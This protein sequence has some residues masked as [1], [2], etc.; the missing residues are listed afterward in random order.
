MFQYNNLKCGDCNRAFCIAIDTDEVKGDTPICP[1]CNS[2]SVNSAA[3]AGSSTQETAQPGGA[4]PL[5][6]L[7]LL[8]AV[9]NLKNSRS[10]PR[11][12]ERCGLRSMWFS[13]EELRTLAQ[14]KSDREVSTVSRELIEWAELE[15][16]QLLFLK[17]ILCKSYAD[18][19]KELGVGA[20]RV[21]LK[22]N[23][24]CDIYGLVDEEEE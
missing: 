22:Y 10:N 17:G 15:F 24:L 5:G 21:T 16:R 3:D 8:A 12:P 20:S 23:N 19:G 7:H 13:Q 14:L 2:K 9:R 11:A 4:G 1:H 18:V 6:M